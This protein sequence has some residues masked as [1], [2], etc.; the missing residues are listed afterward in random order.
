[1]GPIPDHETGPAAA[2]IILTL[3]WGA[4]TALVLFEIVTT[5]AP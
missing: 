2:T 3:L 5:P 4:Y 1:M